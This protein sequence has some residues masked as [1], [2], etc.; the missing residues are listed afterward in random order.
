MK[1]RDLAPQTP[2]LYGVV[3][4]ATHEGADDRVWGARRVARRV[5]NTARRCK[6]HAFARAA[7]PRVSRDSPFPAR[8]PQKSYVTISL[9][10][11]DGHSESDFVWIFSLIGKSNDTKET[12][13]NFWRQAMLMAG[14]D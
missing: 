3:A 14:A 8:K 11:K 7:R 9:Q 13:F 1:F 2:N 6:G 5:A 12:F 4:R 10:G